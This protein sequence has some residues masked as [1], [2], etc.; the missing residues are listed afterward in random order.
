MC[1]S[2]ALFKGTFKKLDAVTKLGNE[3]SNYLH[4]TF[5]ITGLYFSSNLSNSVF[6]NVNS[7]V[8]VPCDLCYISPSPLAGSG[9]QLYHC[10]T[11]KL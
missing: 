6:K 7:I 4:F 9:L 10:N 3:D 5:L 1:F 2:P 11:S 8:V